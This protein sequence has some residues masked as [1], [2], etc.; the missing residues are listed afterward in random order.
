MPSP[1]IVNETKRDP[2]EREP[3]PATSC[4]PHQ[5]LSED[6]AEVF[7]KARRSDRVLPLYLSELAERKIRE[8]ALREAP[9]RLEVLGFLLGD[10]STWKGALYADCRDVV[11]TKLRSSSSKVRFSPDAFPDLFLQLDDSGFD[12]ILVGW[13]HSHPGHTCFL[14]RTDLDTQRSMFNQ[15]YHAALVIDPVN[16]AVKA[17]RLTRQGSDY[18]EVPFAVYAHPTVSKPR[19]RTRRLRVK[20]SVE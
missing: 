7:E 14:S 9:R 12:Y 10:V 5:W 4:R 18:E 1:K 11:T 15:S 13:Y 6:S 19:G 3:P 20:T 2:E 16:E 8:H 17:F